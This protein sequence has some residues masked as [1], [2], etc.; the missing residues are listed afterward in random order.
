MRITKRPKPSSGVDLSPMLD[1]IF[2]LILFFLVS[3]TFANLPGI[4]LN[5]PESKTSQGTDISG[6]NITVEEDG[7]IWFNESESSMELLQTQLGQVELG[8]FTKE[9]YPVSIQADEKVTN[10]TIVKIFDAIRING[11]TSVSLRTTDVR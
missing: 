9:T 1:V 7:K 5:L 4:T 6:V 3:T 8:N 2:Q 11:F 10:G